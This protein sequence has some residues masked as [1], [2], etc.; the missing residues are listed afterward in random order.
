MIGD[1]TIT[2]YCDRCTHEESFDLTPLA[3]KSWDARNLPGEMRR[4][5]WVKTDDGELFCEDCAIDE[6]R[7][8]GQP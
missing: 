6:R 3:G 2:V 4:A 1:P 8:E 5:G 7:S